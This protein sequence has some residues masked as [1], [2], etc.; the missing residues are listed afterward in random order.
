VLSLV[1]TAAIVL[2]V[3]L[4]SALAYHDVSLAPQERYA[5][6]LDLDARLAGHG[7]VIFNEYDEFAKY[8]LRDARGYSQPEWPHGY[9]HGPYHPNA[10]ADP[11]R[12]PTGK[13]PL[14]VDDLALGYLES[15]PYI[16]LR[17]S[18][19][20]SRPPANFARVFTG[21]YYELWQRRATPR[22]VR[23]KPLGPDILHQAA[24]V[25]AAQ[26]RAWAAL[27]RRDRG[28]IAYVPRP[29]PAGFDVTRPPRPGL[30]NTFGG[31]PLGLVPSGP[32]I[33]RGPVKL[34][35]SDRYE[36]WAEGSFARRMRLSIDGR[37]V[38]VTRAGLNN[39]GAYE[40]LA[41]LRLARGLHAVKISQGGGDLRPGSGGYRSSLRHIG[42][43]W[44]VPVQDRALRV[45]TIDAGQWRRLAGVRADW[46]EIVR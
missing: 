10:L 39:P 12:R 8:F 32:G 2:A 33:L 14:D 24:T 16:I 28:R 11:K 46:L 9:R 4:S 22:V 3:G 1:A 44:F 29:R 17:R 23:H 38:G 6:L 34:S 35:R 5:E 7:P 36:I 21:D 41:T 19:T 37:E 20:S 13:T 15:V 43:L 45:V 42:P 26:A 18:P 27:A 31:F 25:T 40:R 30:W